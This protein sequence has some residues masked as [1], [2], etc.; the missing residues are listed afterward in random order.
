MKI[1]TNAKAGGSSY[2]HNESMKVRSSVKAGGTTYQ[3]NESMK[4]N[5]RPGTGIDRGE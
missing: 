4:C 3:H 5:D 2:Q 1:R